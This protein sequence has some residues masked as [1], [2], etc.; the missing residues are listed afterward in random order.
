MQE[1]LKPVAVAPMGNEL[2]ISWNDG[3]EQYLPLE[4][5]RRSCPCAVCCGEPDVMGMGDAPAR[6]Y[7]PE[8]FL[9]KSYEFIGGYALLFRWAD[10]HS[11]GIYSY[12]LLRSLA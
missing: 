12:Q 3:V 6:S 9:L 5:L 2:A 4:L 10:G 8:S 1:I 7:K 11:S